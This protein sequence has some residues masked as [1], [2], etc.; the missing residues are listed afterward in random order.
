M[1]AALEA[2]IR[3]G[4]G[5]SVDGYLMGDGTFRYGLSYIS[6]LLGYAENYYR[7]LLS[8]LRQVDGHRKPQRTKKEPKKLKALLDKGFTAYQ[9]T[10]RAPR[11]ATGGSS[12]AHTVSYEDFC[13]LV[14]YEAEIGNPRAMGL[15]TASFREL[16]RSRTQEAF[17][18]PEDTL[19]DKLKA[20]Q[21][22]Y[23][24]YLE[25]KLDLEMQ[26]LPGDELYYPV[27]RDWEAI[28]PWETK[29]RRRKAS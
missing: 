29:K 20:F 12:V 8:P 2:T 27:F 4:A 18:L 16:L 21:L 17:D 22:N 7:R 9:I 23:E 24:H 1:Q 28:E 6:D 15:L 10:V 13:V 25:D 3:L 26:W 5:I 19:E 11:T 14:E